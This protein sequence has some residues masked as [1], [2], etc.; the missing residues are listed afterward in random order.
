MKEKLNILRKFVVLSALLAGLLWTVYDTNQTAVSA[1]GCCS[2]CDEV[3][4]LEICPPGQ[5][6][7]KCAEWRSCYIGCDPIC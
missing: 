7:H 1:A 4:W 5:P 6:F 2:P 3:N